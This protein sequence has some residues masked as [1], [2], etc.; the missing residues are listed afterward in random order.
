[1][2]LNEPVPRPESKYKSVGVCAQEMPL[3]HDG[4]RMFLERMGKYSQA[5]MA[6]SC[7]KTLSGGIK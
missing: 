6:D 2:F 7:L 5:T 1:M 3:Q 4:S